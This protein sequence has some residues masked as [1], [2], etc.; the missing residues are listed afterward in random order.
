[1]SVREVLVTGRLGSH[2]VSIVDTI[3]RLPR[4]RRAL[5]EENRVADEIMA[6]LGLTRWSSTPASDLALGTR[7]ML[8]LGRAIAGGSSLVL[9]DEV[10]SGLDEDDIHELVR[11]LHKMRDAGLTVVLVEHNFSL[12]RSMADEV[13]VLA[14]GRVIAKGTPDEV[15]AHPDV[16]RFYLGEGVGIAGTR[17][18]PEQGGQHG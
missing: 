15:A 3:L 13:V 6:Q 17:V 18:T 14:E 16:V 12:V 7:R 9:L 11:V 8:E 4:H 1:L 5:A 10:A 2:P